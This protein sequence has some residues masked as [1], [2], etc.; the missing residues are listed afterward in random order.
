MSKLSFRGKFAD[1]S[2]VTSASVLLAIFLHPHVIQRIDIMGWL[3][4]AEDFQELINIV[5]A[6]ALARR[7]RLEH[8]QQR[9]RNFFRRFFYNDGFRARYCLPKSMLFLTSFL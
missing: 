7:C 2:S 4:D 6:P 3:S 5:A 1:H 8:Y 9:R